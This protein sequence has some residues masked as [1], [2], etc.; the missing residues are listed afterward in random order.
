MG[1]ANLG[2]TCFMNTCLQIMAHTFELNEVI[3]K[4]DPRPTDL[5][6][7]DLRP[8]DLRSADSVVAVQWRDLLVELWKRRDKESVLHP[9]RFLFYIQKTAEKKGNA[10][11]TGYAQ[12]DFSEFL[13][14]FVQEL[15]GATKRPMEV[16]I[17]GT[18]TND[19][20]TVAMECY[21]MLQT[22]YAKEYSEVLTIL[23]GVAVSEL[24]PVTSFDKKR[25]SV[26]PELFY[27]L[28]VT[29]APSLVESLNTY[30]KEELIEDWTNEE[31]GVQENVIKRIR[32]WSLPP[33]VT[34]TL[35]RFNNA[36]KKDNTMVQ[37]PISN[38]SM[39]PYVCGYKK[40]ITIYDLYGV[41]CHIGTT[42]GGH[43]F[44][45]VKN[46][47]TG[48]WYCYNDEHVTAIEDEKDIVNP[49]AYC[50]FYRRCSTSN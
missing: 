4:P 22:E 49:Y 35:K 28:D 29:V 3:L 45:M 42:R 15:H 2:N 37:Y 1:L 34:I 30:F 24:L 43:Y 41:A 9:K 39:E 48:K 40:D 5:R 23:H 21:K 44:A 46:G 47:M 50:L 20:D 10:C 27:T 12:N 26:V 19:V 6:S 8:T 32:I 31:T 18:V 11:F 14:F 7:T 17:R 16:T 36:G 13:H 25:H 33:I 38:L